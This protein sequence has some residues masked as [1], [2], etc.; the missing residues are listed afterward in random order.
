M[1]QNSEIRFIVFNK[2]N[3]NFELYQHQILVV[4]SLNNDKLTVKISPC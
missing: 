2:T 1:I 3:D 4:Q